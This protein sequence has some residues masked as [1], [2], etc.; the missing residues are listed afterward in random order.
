[1]KRAICFLM[2]LCAIL[3]LSTLAVAKE[4]EI[5][6]V[7]GLTLEDSLLSNEEIIQGFLDDPTLSDTQK[8]HILDKVNTLAALNAEN[9]IAP[10][11]D[12]DME[13]ILN[14][15][16]I[17]QETNRYCSAAVAQQ[18]LTYYGGSFGSQADIYS[19]V[20]N[21]SPDLN[22][23]ITYINR[24]QDSNTMIWQK[25]SGQRELDNIIRTAYKEN[26]PIILA[27]KVSAENAQNNKWPYKT[28]GHFTNL[29]GFVSD[30]QYLFADPYYFDKYVAGA[31]NNPAGEGYHYESYSN[32]IDANS[33]YGNDYNYLAW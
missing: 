31:S 29:C 20:F 19:K 18:T 26:T 10:H 2:V 23:I 16:A 27:V 4:D 1:M 22:K 14:I 25:F 15:P 6:P 9:D 30:H 11:Y 3:S 7:G 28:G 33:G 32:L 13:Y 12:P 5:V 17:M 21:S 8:Q 24:N